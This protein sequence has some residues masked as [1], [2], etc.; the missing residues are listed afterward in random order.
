MS[1]QDEDFDWNQ[2]Y[3]GQASDYE[4]PDQRMLEIVAGLSPGR[5]LDIGCGAGGLLVALAG[6]GWTV[7]GIDIASKAIEAARG[8]MA[9]RGIAAELQVADASQWTSNGS[10]D[11]V[12]N[13]FALPETREQQ[14]RI[15]A[16]CRQLLSPGGHVLIKDFDKPPTD[17][18]AFLRF[19]C[20]TLE[21]LRSDFEG[22]EI[23]QAEIVETPAHV[24]H[25]E[26]QGHGTPWSAILFHARKPL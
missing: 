5:A 17:N 6:A 25:G 16:T 19:H 18:P 14:A 22:F 11:L 20:P 24:H 3:T 1:E 15:F 4:P 13:S 9:E 23:L 12:T 2:I 7:S 10:F 8:V 26:E 21:E